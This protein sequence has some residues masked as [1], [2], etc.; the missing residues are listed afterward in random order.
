MICQSVILDCYDSYRSGN[1]IMSFGNS[2]INCISIVDTS[3]RLKPNAILS[4]CPKLKIVALKSIHNIKAQEEI[5]YSYHAEYRFPPP[6][7]EFI[8]IF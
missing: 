2:L 1:C 8:V 4:A 5:I 6:E 7:N 3:R